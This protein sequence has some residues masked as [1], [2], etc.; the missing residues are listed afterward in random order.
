MSKRDYYDIMGISRQASDDDIKKAYRKLAMKYHPDRNAG[1]TEAEE[2]FKEVKEAYEVL[3]EPEKRAAYDRFGH[4][5]VNSQSGGANAGFSGFDF[6]DIFSD[7]FGGTGGRQTRAGPQRGADLRYNMEITLEEAAHGCEKQIKIP[8]VEECD[9]C[10]GSG[11]KPGS[12]VETCPDCHGHGQVRINQG[13]FQFQQT[14][15]RCQ[16]S[17]KLIKDPCRSCHGQGQKQGSKTLQV[18]IPAGADDGD[19]IRLSGE[20]RPGESGGAKGDLY[21]VTHLKPHSVFTRDGTNL[22][23]EMPISF[24]IAALGGEIEVPTLDGMAKVKIQPETQTGKILRLRGKGIR[25]IRTANQGDLMCHVVVE[26][27]VKLNER[28]K[29]LLREFEN[30]SEEQHSNPRSKS[31]MDKLKDFFAGKN[32]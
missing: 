12:K 3:S 20:G 17:G 30:L 11:A 18:R 31:F 8:T 24:G 2:K 27:P 4:E 5:G 1:N 25:S 23:C 16:G 22:H 10:S 29:E 28:Q 6:S 15:P 9:V 13:F 26:T 19:R 14:C 7:I 21:I 32:L